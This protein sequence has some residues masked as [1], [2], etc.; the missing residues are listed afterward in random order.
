MKKLLILLTLSIILNACSFI[1]KQSKSTPK[2]DTLKVD[3]WSGNRSAIRQDYERDVLKA[4]LKITEKE[5]GPWTIKET[6][7]EYPGN[8]ESKVFKTKNHD[9][10]VTIAG[11]QKF[12]KEDYIMV[13]NPIA[14]NLLGYRIPIIKSENK[15][16]IDIAIQNSEIKKLVHG[17]PETWSD[18]GIFRHNAYAVS[19]EGD[20][21]DIFER[22]QTENFDYTT[23]GANE[24]ISVYKNRASLQKN[25]VIEDSLMFFYPFP[26]VFYLNPE[27]KDMAK[28]LSTGLENLEKDKAL[29]SIFDTYY[30]D[31]IQDLKLNHR[32]IIT[33]ENPLIPETFSK[34]KPDLGMF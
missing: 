22:L 16:K 31:I 26:L 24:V 2:T 4:I 30:K 1:G 27:K 29:D 17:I 32:K 8:Q 25:L 3:F 33:L 6:K 28:R 20:F 12:D 34:L 15:D 13:E 9:V 10:F 18:A 7:T 14:K 19:E 23:F 5:F 21:D 11:N